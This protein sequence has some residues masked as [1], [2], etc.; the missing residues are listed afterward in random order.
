MKKTVEFINFPGPREL[1]ADKAGVIEKLVELDTNDTFHDVKSKILDA[2]GKTE[3]D[4]F[5]KVFLQQSIEIRDLDSTQYKDKKFFEVGAF[6]FNDPIEVHFKRVPVLFLLYTSSKK[7]KRKVLH[8][9]PKQKI[10]DVESLVKRKFGI[11]ESVNVDLVHQGFKLDESKTLND[12]SK[13][14]PAHSIKVVARILEEGL[15][16]QYMPLE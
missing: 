9:D 10:S 2:F 15:D 12:F 7:T 11:L 13:F 5:G 1:E 14:D 6:D 4:T 8:I 3:K 16:E